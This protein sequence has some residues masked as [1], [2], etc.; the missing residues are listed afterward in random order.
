M[1]YTGYWEFD[2]AD[3]YRKLSNVVPVK[4]NDT[5]YLNVSFVPGKISNTVPMIRH[6]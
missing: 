3:S 1:L 6:I 2:W 5:D 4:I